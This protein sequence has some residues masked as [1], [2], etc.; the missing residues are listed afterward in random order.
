MN[1]QLRQYI[2][3]D[4][5]PHYIKLDFAG[6]HFALCHHRKLM[7]APKDAYQIEI[8]QSLLIDK[9]NDDEFRKIFKQLALTAINADNWK[10]TITAT[11]EKLEKKDIDLKFQDCSEFFKVLRNRYEDISDCFNSDCGIRLMWFDSEI[12]E[13]VVHDL[14]VEKRIPAVLSVH[15]EILCHPDYVNL[16]Y[17][18]MITAYRKILKRDLKNALKNKGLKSLPDYIKPTITIE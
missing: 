3:I 18:E 7:S 10:D 17:D 16:V 4:C 15:D 2:S 1:K 6:H 8:D 13:A 14:M 11:M 5:S 12:I 9:R